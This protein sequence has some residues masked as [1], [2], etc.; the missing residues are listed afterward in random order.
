M[1]RKPGGTEEL[2][3]RTPECMGERERGR[4]WRCSDCHT[5]YY[6]VPGVLE[7]IQ[8]ERVMGKVLERL[9]RAGE[10]MIGKDWPPEGWKR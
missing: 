1:N 9:A 6:D 3:H 7:A 4:H 10:E 8:M 2:L 5:L